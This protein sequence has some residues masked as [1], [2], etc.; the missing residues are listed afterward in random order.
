MSK[1]YPRHYIPALLYFFFF[2]PSYYLYG[3]NSEK[4][5]FLSY[6]GGHAFFFKSDF[7]LFY[8]LY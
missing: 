8:F 4:N 7:I 2:Y 5:Q 6:S 1:V 3:L